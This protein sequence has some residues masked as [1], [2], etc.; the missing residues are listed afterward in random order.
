MLRQITVA[1]GLA[2]M[3][4]PLS[5]QAAE[6]SVVLDIKNADCVLCPP[7]VKQSLMRVPGVKT[8]EIKQANHMADFMATITFDDA[9]TT[10]P[11]LAAAPTNA[12]YP[13]K[14]AN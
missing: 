10:V 3:L 2:L 1:A 9:I 7:I 12:G 11:T 14:V 6:K 8:V 4:A 5:V 13:T